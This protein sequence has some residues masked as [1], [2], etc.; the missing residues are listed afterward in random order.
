[1]NENNIIRLY[2]YLKNNYQRFYNNQVQYN[3]VC[4]L[5]NYHYFIRCTPK[6]LKI[7]AVN[8]TN[9]SDIIIYS[10]SDHNELIALID[11][12]LFLRT[13]FANIVNQLSYYSYMILNRTRPSGTNIDN[14]LYIRIR[15]TYESYKR[16]HSDYLNRQ[17]NTVRLDLNDSILSSARNIF[18]N[19][20]VERVQLSGQNALSE[21]RARAIISEQVERRIQEFARQERYRENSERIN[22][23]LRELGNRLEEL[24]R[25]LYERERQR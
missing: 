5:R 8:K 13:V 2:Y 10:F 21:E 25:R 24:S 1:M 23:Q 18:I 22:Y 11:K 7:K 17:D 9:K 14:S 16:Q 15:K 6:E 4:S 12:R 19:D 20:R 3:Y